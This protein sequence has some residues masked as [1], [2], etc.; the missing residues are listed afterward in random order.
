MNTLTNKAFYLFF[1][2][3]GVL[4]GDITEVSNVTSDDC[5]IGPVLGLDGFVQSIQHGHSIIALLSKIS[6]QNSVCIGFHSK[7]REG[8][9]LALLHLL[10]AE[11][12]PACQIMAV[13]DPEL[14]PGVESTSPC[15]E[16]RENGVIVSG[17]GIELDGKQ[18]VRNALAYVTGC[19]KDKTYIF[20]DGPS[21]IAQAREEGYHTRRIGDVTLYE[22]V[23]DIHDI[24]CQD[25]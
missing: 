18:C 15:V 2:N 4:D 21:V 16:V 5:V 25:K 7:N 11:G 20:D 9:Q 14:Y 17:Y 19:E 1:D 22:A 12:F 3:G 23:K 13:Y 8:D 10:N 24:I 6:E